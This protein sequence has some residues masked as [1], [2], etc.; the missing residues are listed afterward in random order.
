ML[1]QATAREAA[2]KECK[3]TTSVPLGA[4]MAQAELQAEVAQCSTV[5]ELCQQLEMK[6]EALVLSERLTAA[7]AKAQALAKAESQSSVQQ[8]SVW[9]TSGHTSMQKSSNPSFNPVT[10]WDMDEVGF[11]SH[12]CDARAHD[13]PLFEGSK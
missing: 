1:F 6:A 3:A 11:H 8:Q 7:R 10:G 12:P 13:G 5:L 4:A 9:D 2:R